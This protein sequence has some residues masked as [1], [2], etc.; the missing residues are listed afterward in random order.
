MTASENGSY[1]FESVPSV[2]LTTVIA[3]DGNYYKDTY[4]IYRLVV[5]ITDNNEYL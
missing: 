2:E 4:G 3:T 1:F 5:I